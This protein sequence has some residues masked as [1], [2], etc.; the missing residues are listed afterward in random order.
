VVRSDGAKCG[1]PSRLSQISEKA[2]KRENVS[3]SRISEEA[4]KR[5]VGQ[6]DHVVLDN[7]RV[8]RFGPI[9]P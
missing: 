8:D 2:K 9:C 6:N 4:K 5:E 1:V 7:N 3:V